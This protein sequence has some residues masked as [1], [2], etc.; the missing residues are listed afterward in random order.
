MIT[1]IN[2]SITPAPA[3]NVAFKNK[4]INTVCKPSSNNFFKQ[5]L[6][7]I[8][9]E[10]YEPYF[11]FFAGLFGR[12]LVYD[13]ETG[14]LSAIE[15]LKDG[16][17]IEIKHFYPGTKKVQEIDEYSNGVITKM[18]GFQKNGKNVNWVVEHTESKDI[19]THYYPN[20]INCK[21]VQVDFNDGNSEIKYYS[22]KG[23]LNKIET[24]TN[25]I[26]TKEIRLFDNHK[27]IRN[28]NNGELA[29]QIVYFSKSPIKSLIPE[30]Y[31][32]KT[33]IKDYVTEFN[34]NK[35][36]KTTIHGIKSN[37]DLYTM[38]VM[39][40]PDKDT[41]KLT[42]YKENGKELYVEIINK[43]SRKRTVTYSKA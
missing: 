34:Q 3:R 36:V 15:K 13:Q 39:E 5:N 17:A 7:M 6:H 21:T 11:N 18:T 16:K 26:K 29:N 20:G 24:Y 12:H 23:Y 31:Q 2:N 25:D 30:G 37:G 33:P 4:R 35:P 32:R 19:T 9:M 41:I 43:C 28:F 8:K 40:Y 27:I 22:P 10:V 38:G 42:K 1:P 14:K